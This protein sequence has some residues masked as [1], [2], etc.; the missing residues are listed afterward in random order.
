MARRAFLIIRSFSTHDAFEAFAQAA[1]ARASAKRVAQRPLHQIAAL[2]PGSVP[3]H[4]LI[5]E[6]PDEAAARAAW[7]AMDPAPI[8]I[9]RPPCVLLVPAIPDGGLGP[10]LDFVPQ[11]HNVIA[12]PGQPP[13]F[14]L[15]EGTPTDEAA[16]EAYRGI[17]LPMLKERGAYYLAFEL[18]DGVKVLS[19]DWSE[20]VFAISRWSRRH[21]AEDFWLDARYQGEAIPIRAGNSA[22]EVVILEGERDDG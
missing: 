22:F 11:P 8:S 7:Q 16:M 10:D 1:A 15:I 9:P 21:L 3:L 6:F 4:T 13:T 19:G 5:L 12:G 20:S 2:E 18:G 14:M 17:I